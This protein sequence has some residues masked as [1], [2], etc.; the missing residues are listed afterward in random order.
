MK[1]LLQ[2]GADLRKL[3]IRNEHSFLNIVTQCGWSQND[4]ETAYEVL[5]TF[6]DTGLDGKLLKTAV[7]EIMFFRSPDTLR[8]LTLLLQVGVQVDFSISENTWSWESGSARTGYT[9]LQEIFRQLDSRL[10]DVAQHSKC[11]I[12]RYSV[13][14]SVGSGC[15]WKQALSS[16]CMKK[17]LIWMTNWSIWRWLWAQFMTRQSVPRGK[18]GPIAVVRQSSPICSIVSK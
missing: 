17:R 5:S 9:P 1:T 16:D 7:E 10:K 4:K 2:H 14:I 15:S 3:L 8:Q 6:L 13:L 11:L 12:A 18:A